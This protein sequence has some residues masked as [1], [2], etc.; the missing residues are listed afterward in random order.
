MADIKWD[1]LYRVLNE[2]AD[3]FV[4][5]AQDNIQAN[6]NYASGQL[7]Q[8]MGEEREIT[9]ENDYLSVKVSL[10]DYW[11]YLEN[12]TGPHM[13]PIDAIRR[14]VEV[15]FNVPEIEGIA[16]AVANKIKK[17]GTDAHPFFEQ[18]KSVA[19]EQFENSIAYA[20]QEDMLGYMEDTVLNDLANTL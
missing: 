16:W 9:F 17:E 3:Y 10:M 1:N 15:K 12:G 20:L 11:V 8:T 14:W 5:V 7:S 4:Q 6:G 2:Y 18:S 13:P 19:L